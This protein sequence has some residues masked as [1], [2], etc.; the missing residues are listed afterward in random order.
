MAQP[1][2]NSL[3][4]DR[5]PLIVLVC[6]ITALTGVSGLLL[7]LEPTPLA[8]IGGPILTV[9]DS[10][11]RGFDE[12]L[13]NQR[14]LDEQRWQAII[15]HHS[16]TSAGSASALGSTHQSLGHG[17]LLYHFVVGNGNGADDGQVQIGYRW[18]RQAGGPHV[19]DGPNAAW[20]NQHAIAICLVGDGDLRSPTA[21]QMDQLVGLV[22][23]LQKRLAIPADRVLLHANVA[24]TTS[25][26]LL[27]PTSAFRQ[28]LLEV[29][30]R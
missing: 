20:L 6:L 18:N 24:A 15:I 7:L 25:P 16:G 4:F 14:D 28:Q 5:R 17:G 27:F 8:P 19:P 26:G 22:T 2:L 1:K 30:T 11:P 3:P 13:A 12:L 21:R 23:S 9:L 10:T 29:E